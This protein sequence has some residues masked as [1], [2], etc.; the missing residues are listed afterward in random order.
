[1]GERLGRLAEH[2]S[3]PVGTRLEIAKAL[4]TRVD[5]FQILG[6]L[7]RLSEASPRSGEL[8]LELAA[9]SDKALEDLG[10]ADYQDDEDQKQLLT[11]LARLARRP[12]LGA[13]RTQSDARKKRILYALFEGARKEI[14]GVVKVLKALADDQVL[15][16]GL[17]KDLEE[18]LPAW[19]P[20]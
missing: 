18:R 19:L 10:A 20:R 13:D 9:I 1:M 8:S 3:T 6:A 4:A 7:S 5:N 14:P 17:A 15:P 12:T 16:A 2:E 11:I